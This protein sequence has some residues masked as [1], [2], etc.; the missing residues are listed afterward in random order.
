MPETKVA[1]VILNY[2]GKHHLQN[3][4]PSVVEFSQGHA[5]YIAD[6]CSTDDSVSFI[7]NTYPEIQLLINPK[8]LGYAE[9][10]NQAL[11]HIHSEYYILL[12]SDVE[13]S[14][15]WITTLLEAME[16]NPKA[17]ACQPK[18]LDYRNR[19]FF[20]YA[21]ACGGYIDSLGYPFCRG[22]L[23]DQLEQDKAQY[24]TS[25]E[26]FWASGACIMVRAEV[27]HRAG[28][29]DGDFFAHMEEIDLC[30]RIKN[31]GYSIL[32]EPRS[33]VYHLG[34]GTLEKQSTK[35]TYL[36]FRNNISTLF[37]NEKGFK[38]LYKIP[39]R[40]ILDGIA[41]IKFLF[42]GQL[43]HTIAVLKAHFHF[44]TWIPSL[45][46]KRRHIRAQPGFRYSK[47]GVYRG[48][49]VFEYYVLGRKTF[50]GLKQGFF[51]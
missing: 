8:N 3:F 39:L 21:G 15:G 18:L 22:R 16:N 12:N 40:L 36:N 33:R 19:D 51:S 41:G 30:W 13:V 44:Y 50:S 46:K 27:F 25:V 49:I 24:N 26:I 7:K 23:F 14:P 45:I 4:L 38:L 9:G 32:V 28:G 2:N 47:T 37:K 48:S 17:G 31:L 6:N 20:E 42:S 11:K 34:G 29:L 1:V 5:I 10:Y 35:K 43:G